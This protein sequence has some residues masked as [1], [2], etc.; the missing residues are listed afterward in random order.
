MLERAHT[1]M[2]AGATG[3]IFGRNVWQRPQD[4]A[5]AISRRIHEVLAQHGVPA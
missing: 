4:D 3:L 5:L 2:D 1:A